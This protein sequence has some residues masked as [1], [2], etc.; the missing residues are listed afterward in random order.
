MSNIS[1]DYTDEKTW[2]LLQKGHSV[3]C[4]QLEQPLAK[5][6]L[7]RIKPSN[8]WEL[9]AVGAA[10]RPGPLMSN[11]TEEYAQ[12]KE[13]GS[14]E[15]YNNP[16]VDEIF[17]TTHN[18][19]LFQEQI[20]KLGEKLAWPHLE[21]NKRLVKV[22]ALRKAV[23]KKN[24]Q[25]ILEIGKE[26]VEGCLHNNVE[27]ELA[28]RLFDLIKKSGRYAFN[29]SHA[30]QYAEIGFQTAWLKAN[31]PL[32]FFVTYL[33]YAKF[34]PYKWEA[35]KSLVDEAKVLDIKILPPNFNQK[36][37]HFKVEKD[38][39]IRYG[40]SHIKHIGKAA[41]KLIKSCP[42]ITHWSEWVK[43]CFT[44]EYGRKLDK[45]AAKNLILTGAFSDLGISRSSLDNIY[46]CLSKLSDVEVAHVAARCTIETP[47]EELANL[48]I[49]SSQVVSVARREAMVASLSKLIQVDLPDDPAWIENEEMSLMGAALT[50]CAVDKKVTI[51]ANTVLESIGDIP[52]WTK[53]NLAVVLDEVRYTVTKKGNNPG[54][55]MAIVSFH[56]AT[57]SMTNVPVFPDQFAQYSD[58]LIPK[59][60]I[61]INMIA[62]KN[63]WVIE[64]I[65][66]L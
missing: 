17:A 7:R 3:G 54:Q 13:A 22:D 28:D 41:C 65:Y 42:P 23:G 45:S 46:S 20:M 11:M 5:K 30:F 37:L 49:E 48:V 6:W 15:S 34:R 2:A 16:I 60:C 55:K 9:A 19:C 58:F 38:N 66:P 62:R 32:H 40:L 47:I 39:E 64:R 44:K 26:F 8:L 57:A 33:S 14:F 61:S 18:I 31:Y 35:I 59:S 1:V 10:L 53:H 36:N 27:P 63:G 52:E 51:G 12:N 43:L 25:K 56:D 29:L 21:E 4:F 24:Q 50:A